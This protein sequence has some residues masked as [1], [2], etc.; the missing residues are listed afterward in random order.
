MPKALYYQAAF[1]IASLWL[2]SGCGGRGYEGGQRAEVKGKVT[3]D[4]EPVTK[5]ALNLIPIGHQGNKVSV[6]IKDGA[7]AISEA[8]GPNFGK[9][10]VEVYYFKPLNAATA[11]ADAEAA[12]ATQQVIP[13]QFNSQSTLELDVNAAKMEKAFDLSSR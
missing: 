8:T 5:G 3:F 6:P 1:A 13:P 12:S 11:T 10:R 2:I 4:G 9:Y 7:Y